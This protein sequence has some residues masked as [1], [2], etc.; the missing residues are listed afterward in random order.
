MKV[1]LYKRYRE[2]TILLSLVI[3]FMAPG[4]AVAATLTSASVTLSN[5]QPSVTSNYTFQASGLTSTSIQCISLQFNSA[6][7]MSGSV[8]TGFSSTAATLSVSSTLITSSSWTVTASTNGTVQLTD[9]TGATPASS[10]NIILQNITNGSTAGTP[11]FL[12][13]DTYTSSSCSG[14]VDNATVGF[15]YNTG[16]SVSVTVNPLLSFSVASLPSGTN[17]NGATTNF[18]TTSTTIPFGT[19]PT[20]STNGIGAQALTVSTNSGNG[21]G[22]TLA[23]TGPL[24]NGTHNFTNVSGTNSSPAA[25][26]AAGTEGF[27]YT[28][29][30][31]SQFAS[32]LW[33]GLSTSPAT[34][35][36]SSSAASSVTTDVGYQIG[37]SATTPPGSY[38]TT[39][40]YTL[41]PVY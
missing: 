10:G 27:G 40:I 1:R 4:S 3:L 6:S 18:A 38:S 24:S 14:A 2:L 16:Q 26:T 20:I 12:A 13:V 7:N 11:Y 41:T 31:E 34:I 23:Y 8:P 5:A 37:L 17:I 39:V 28:T 29:T 25:F 9:S 36:N 35:A 33:A 21:Y 32:N 30:G 22:L 19:I 15:I